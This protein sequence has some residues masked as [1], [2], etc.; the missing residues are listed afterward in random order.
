MGIFLS[1][2][3]NSKYPFT[4]FLY[5]LKK[6]DIQSSRYLN[7]YSNRLKNPIIYRKKFTIDRICYF[8][9]LEIGYNASP[10]LLRCIIETSGRIRKYEITEGM[11]LRG[12]TP[13]AVSYR[14]RT[15]SGA[16]PF[17]YSAALRNDL[18]YIKKYLHIE[19]MSLAGIC[20]KGSRIRAHLPLLKAYR[21]GAWLAGR[22]IDAPNDNCTFQYEYPILKATQEICNI[23]GSTSAFARNDLSLAKD[24]L[25]K[26][27]YGITRYHG[28][29]L[30]KYVLFKLYN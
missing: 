11:H 25:E 24:C 4:S 29:H 12:H 13:Y 8:N 15:Y 9:P 23:K 30:R 22:E 20:F 17:I 26:P 21:H 5:T 28:N 6:Y 7:S 2:K 10:E 3:I 14:K 16:E 19:D 18:R 27:C 1:R